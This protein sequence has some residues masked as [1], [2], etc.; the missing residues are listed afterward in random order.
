VHHHAEHY[1]LPSNYQSLTFTARA[2]F[3]GTGNALNNVIT[4]GAATTRWTAAWARTAWSAAQARHY[5]V[6]NAGDV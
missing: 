4:G 2:N 1:T 5:I 3:A 6:D